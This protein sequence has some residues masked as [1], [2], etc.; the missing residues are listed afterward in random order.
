LGQCICRR[1]F[2]LAVWK[3]VPCWYYCLCRLLVFCVGSNWPHGAARLEY[4]LSADNGQ[5]S[6]SL[7]FQY[8]TCWDTVLIPNLCVWCSVWGLCLYTGF[9]SLY[10]VW[11]HLSFGI[12]F[13]TQFY[14]LRASC[15]KNL[16][17]CVWFLFTLYKG[18][19]LT[20]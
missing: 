13:I 2:E 18:A 15:F 16:N 14:R 4:V 9:T 20:T 5:E 6:I 12:L 8:F 1:G 3:I 10:T 7:I 17:W 19:L 11:V